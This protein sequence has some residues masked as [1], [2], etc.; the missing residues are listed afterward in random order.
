MAVSKKG[1]A[2]RDEASA[3]QQ[4]T[5]MPMY[6]GNEPDPGTLPAGGGMQPAH[7]PNP[8]ASG[9]ASGQEVTDT[10][11][12]AFAMSHG[13]VKDWVGSA[14]RVLRASMADFAIAQLLVTVGAVVSCGLLIGPL[15]AGLLRFARKRMAGIDAELKELFVAFDK[16]TF[17]PAWLVGLGFFAATV[18]ILT[19]HMAGIYVLGL[20]PGLGMLLVS[21]AYLA[22][23]VVVAAL[24]GAWLLTLFL[25]NELERPVGEAW[26][27]VWRMFLVDWWGASGLFIVTGA[28]PVLGVLL[29]GAGVLIGGPLGVLIAA[30]ASRELFEQN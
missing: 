2:P 27:T 3:S 9:D 17:L 8:G 22:V 12:P 10:A 13:Q 7:L 20:V 14:W 4:Y 11:L 19:I 1:E 24:A 21:S 6:H 26:E 5:E 25:V 16:E 15:A 29:A 23:V 30:H 18:L 28:A